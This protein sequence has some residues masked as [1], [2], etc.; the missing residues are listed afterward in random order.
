MLD[1]VLAFYAALVARDSTVLSD[2]VLKSDFTGTL[3]NMLT[4]LEL[5]NDPLWLIS[6]AAG[7]AELKASGITKAEKVLV[8]FSLSESARQGAYMRS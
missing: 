7:P 3:H 2:L 5:S 8:S 4:S 6:T 1:T